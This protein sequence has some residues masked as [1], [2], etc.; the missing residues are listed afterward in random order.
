MLKMQ[1][2]KAKFCR[3]TWML[4]SDN[5]QISGSFQNIPSINSAQINSLFSAP[6]S[7]MIA[8]LVLCSVQNL[9]YR[10]KLFAIIL[11]SYFFKYCYVPK[12]PFVRDYQSKSVYV[13]LHRPEMKVLKPTC[14][15][16][17]FF[18]LCTSAFQG[19]TTST[20]NRHHRTEMLWKS[21]ASF[22]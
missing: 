11:L 19:F 1:H 16:L 12:L 21:Q 15:K 14:L 10:T 18:F 17:R 5:Q 13:L 9:T 20:V 7:W 3:K 8:C 6:F 22:I 2:R 4:Q